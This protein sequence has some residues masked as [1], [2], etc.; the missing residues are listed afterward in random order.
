MKR[1]M[2]VDDE[3]IITT[4]LEK[5]LTSMGY[6]VVGV[7]SSG[8]EALTLAEE[9][10]PDLVLMDIVMPGTVDGI[11]AAAKIRSELDIPII[12]L[13]AFAD[14]SNINR[15]KSAE[16]FGYIVK[17]FH[18]KEVQASIEVALH[19]RMI[20]RRLRDNE[21]LY[22][23]I[24]R[25]AFD[26]III[27]DVEGRIL[28][29][30]ER[31]VQFLCWERE[32]L[33]DSDA[34]LFLPRERQRR[35]RKVS[36]GNKRRLMDGVLLTG[37][38]R[39]VAVRISASD[40]SYSGHHA[41]LQ[42]LSE[43]APHKTVKKGWKHFFK[44]QALSEEQV[45]KGDTKTDEGFRGAGPGTGDKEDVVP[46]CASCKKIQISPSNWIG[47]ES[48]FKELYGVDFSHGICSEC[49]HRLWPDMPREVQGETNV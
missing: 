24:M 26:P 35:S 29:V 2:L 40:V 8:E 46:I 48:F 33:I 6:A 44:R 5:R 10:K 43:V 36:I 13:T 17:P 11:D 27:T 41:V 18:E 23:T 1:I 34:S 39:E 45:R 3:A 47:F 30:N 12:F 20:E 32:E 15:A 19:K 42:I 7:A 14:E 28:E 16:P 25:E 21:E 37:D 22:R 9:I 49:A 4:Q 38:G 31:A